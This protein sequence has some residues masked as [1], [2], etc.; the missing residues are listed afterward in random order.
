[1]INKIKI[2]T[3][4]FLKDYYNSLRIV[5]DKKI[6]KK[7]I[8]FWLLIIFFTALIYLSSKVTTYL[9]AAGEPILFI[10][11]YLPIIASVMLF[12]LIAITCNILYYSNDLKHILPF[13]IKSTEILLAKLNTSIIVMYFMEF[14]FL[15]I[16]FTIYGIQVIRTLAYFPLMI[17]CLIIFPI[18]YAIIISTIMIL[19]MRLNKIIKNKN[20]LQL[21]VV[22]GLTFIISFLVMINMQKIIIKD[23]DEGLEK[24]QIIS[25]K[26]DEINKSF[27]VINPIIKILNNSEFLETAKNIISLILLNIFSLI[28]YLAL[29]RKI[30]LKD[31]LRIINNSNKNKKVQKQNK[32][33]EQNKLKTYLKTDIKKLFKNPVLFIQNIFQYV[34]IAMIFILILNIFMPMIIDYVKKEDLINQI[35]LE[36]FKLQST[37]IAVGIIQILF[38]FTNLSLTAISREGKNAVFMK[39]IPLSLYEQFNI[40]T[41]PQI[42]LNTIIFIIGLIITYFKIVEIPILNYI[43]IFITVMILNIINSNI[44]VLLD[45]KKPNLNWDDE[46]AISKNNGNKLYQYVI[47]IGTFIV[48]NYLSKVFYNFNFVN[49]IIILNIILIV[50]YILLKIYIKKNIKKLFKNIY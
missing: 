38:V 19:V 1:M 16:P 47:C 48:L 23:V 10:K 27:L 31:V 34:F 2:L 7:S 50:I 12:Q 21:V 42:I 4:I 9:E 39:Y 49:S 18:F 26:A 6:N 15:L 3:K 32:Y 37:L 8:Y 25:I 43:I 20:I 46:G 44:M 14:M 30:Y 29:G 33:K 5:N 35:G 36:N 11:I 17:I 45:L 13:P 40:K 28:I 24:L 22:T 41:L